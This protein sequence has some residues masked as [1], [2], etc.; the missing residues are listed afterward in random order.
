MFFGLFGP[1]FAETTHALYGS[2]V[3]EARR[4]VFYRDLA[5]PDTIT[6]RFDM[7]VL[8][9]ALVLRRLRDAPKP[10]P[11]TRVRRGAGA[12]DPHELGHQL[13]D[14][15]FTEMDRALRETGVGDVSVGKRIKKLAAAYNGRALAYD[16]ALDAGDD[17]ALAAALARNLLAGLD[18]RSTAPALA[19][20][21]RAAADVLATVPVGDVVAGRIPWPADAAPSPR[22]TP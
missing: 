6:G 4:P 15:F 11:G 2:I 5:V 10:A 7:L 3:A 13:L 21:V 20:W 17:E 22:I 8:V 16:A 18:D 9:T 14:F 19:A 12:T 1:T